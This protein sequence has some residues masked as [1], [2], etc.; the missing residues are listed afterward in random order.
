MAWYKDNS[1]PRQGVVLP[2]SCKFL[3]VF[4]TYSLLNMASLD[5]MLQIACL[6]TILLSI[7]TLGIEANLIDRASCMNLKYHDYDGRIME[8][9]DVYSELTTALKETGKMTS[10]VYHLMEDYGHLDN[11]FDKIRISDTFFALQ[12]NTGVRIT[13]QP[14]WNI[15]FRKILDLFRPFFPCRT[16]LKL[17]AL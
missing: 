7:W 10:N 5:W 6:L 13:R 11:W 2:R 4:Q 17:T 9:G 1:C 14:R 3:L 15:V 12:G 16:W 8:Y